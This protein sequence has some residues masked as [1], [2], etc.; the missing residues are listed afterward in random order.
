L[1]SFCVTAEAVTYKAGWERISN[2]KLEISDQ[3]R[4]RNGQEKGAGKMPA[5]R[6]RKEQ[7]A[8]EEQPENTHPSR[9]ECD[10]WPPGRED[11]GTRKI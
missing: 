10:G 8:E 1:E 11:W 9:Q 3:K 4:R 7:N 2:L 6:M 5:V